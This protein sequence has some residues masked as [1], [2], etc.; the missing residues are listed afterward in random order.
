LTVYH[1]NQVPWPIG[2]E[3]TKDRK[4]G[5]FTTSLSDACARIEK[6]VGA[7]TKHGQPWRTRELW[8]Y[9]DGE[10][11]AKTRFLANQR[12]IKDP[13]VA[14]RFDLD[15]TEYNIVADRY[16]E[17]W[18]N[19]AGIAEY[20]KAIRAQERNG[21]FTAQ[22]MMATF[23]ALPDPNA[24]RPWWVVMGLPEGAP[25]EAIEMTYRTLARQLHPDVPG[26]ST[27]A[28]QELNRAYDEAKEARR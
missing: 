28:M 24:K 14:V 27:E 17:P 19:L 11:G 21:I 22:E 23:A 1:E 9:A 12:G 8:I 20:I 5:P 18:Q 2:R 13:K 7:F 4:S 16:I 3:I 15:G 26:G 6:E 10:I 25:L